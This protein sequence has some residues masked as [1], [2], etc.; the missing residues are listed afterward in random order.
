VKR[1]IVVI[2]LAAAPVF[3]DEVYLKGGGRFSGE[4][5]EQTE[6]SVTVDIGGGYLS[7]PMSTVVRIEEGVSPL[8]EYR[9]R[10]ASVP[11]GD[12]EAWRELAR[13]ATTKTLSSQAWEAYSQVVAILPDD[14]EANRALGRV[15]LNGRWVTEEESYRARGYIEF[16]DQ[17]MTPAERQ[18]ILAERQAREQADRHANEAEIR[19][20]Q[21]DIDAEQQ[22]EDEEF[23]RQTSR[24]DRLQDY[25]DPVA[26]GWGAGPAYWPSP[27][28]YAQPQELGAAPVGGR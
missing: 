7:A 4:I 21:A 9:E 15:L 17:W 14:D 23:E 27:V 26:W 10:A 24:F 5:V 11:G 28:V 1:A 20:I 18:A 13:W 6:D 3:A 8:E 2:A 19:A 16:E 25:G 22:R 12:A